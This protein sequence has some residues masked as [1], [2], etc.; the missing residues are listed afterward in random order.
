MAIALVVDVEVQ[1]TG[2]GTTETTGAVDTTGADFIAVAVIGDGD[3]G[4]LTVS[5]S[6]SN[7]YTPLTRQVQDPKFAQLFYVFN[8]TVGS[9]HTFTATGSVDIF[10]SIGVQAFSGVA[11]FD[12]QSGSSNAGIETTIQPGSLTPPADGALFVIAM[13]DQGETGAHSINQSF[14]ET[15]DFAENGSAAGGGMSY[16]IQGTAAAQ[17]PTYTVSGGPIARACRMATFLTSGQVRFLLTRF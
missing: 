4:T 12:Q 11:S 8:P 5:D 1:N 6:K 3:P 17:N 16:L 9:G 10:C 2:G 15:M 13:V 7:I 14:I